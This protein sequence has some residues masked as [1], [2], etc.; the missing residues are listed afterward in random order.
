[1]KV[2]TYDEWLSVWRLADPAPRYGEIVSRERASVDGFVMPL[3]STYRDIC[4]PAGLSSLFV[5]LSKR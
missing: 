5:G 2:M 3:P 1:M 4:S